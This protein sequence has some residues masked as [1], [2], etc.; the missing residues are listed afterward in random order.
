MCAEPNP[1]LIC[2][3]IPR[4]K[5]CFATLDGLCQYNAY[6]AVQPSQLL[7]SAAMLGFTSC[8]AHSYEAMHACEKANVADRGMMKM[9]S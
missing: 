2:S 4:A 7:Q 9:T 1:L 5:Q 6:A 3:P 8:K